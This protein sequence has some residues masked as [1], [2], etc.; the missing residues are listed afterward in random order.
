MPNEEL[1]ELIQKLE[2]AWILFKRRDDFGEYAAWRILEQVK[3]TLT[4]YLW[5]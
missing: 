3:V 2:D 1:Q 4:S 5:R